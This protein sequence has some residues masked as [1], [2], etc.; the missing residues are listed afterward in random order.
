MSTI[1]YGKQ[2]ENAAHQFNINSIDY[3]RKT[4]FSTLSTNLTFI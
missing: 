1:E 3:S 4:L 2:K